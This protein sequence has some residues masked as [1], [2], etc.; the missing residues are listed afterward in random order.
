MAILGLGKTV[1]GDFL[2]TEDVELLF[3]IAGYVAI[4]LDNAQLY[5][6]LEQKAQQ[7]ERLK[8]FS[9]NIVE[10]L[11]VG[12][13]AIDLDGRI[14][15]WNAQLEPLLGVARAE[16]V[17]R[18]LRRSA[19]ARYGRWRLRHDG[20]RA[21]LHAVQIPLAQPR[22]SQ[23]GVERVHGAAGGENRRAPGPAGIA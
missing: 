1:D 4:A 16:A 10:S 13:L 5:S 14:E 20:G 12:I 21:R 7:I 23:S 18:R 22:R 6:A 3:T 8:D 17:N 19:A 2:T 11:H 15:S 9:E